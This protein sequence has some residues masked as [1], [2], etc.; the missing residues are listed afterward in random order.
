ME[1]KQAE[2]GGGTTEPE[3][4]TVVARR[5]GLRRVSFAAD[6]TSIHVF[7]RDED[8]ETPPDDKPSSE[9]NNAESA[10][11]N[12]SRGDSSAES[13]GFKESPRRR[14]D[15]DGG[16]DADDDEEERMLFVRNMDYSSPGSAA[17]SMTSND[18]DNFFGPVSTSFIRTG[19]LSMDSATSDDNHDITMDSTAFSLHFRNLV[20]SNER[21]SSSEGNFKTPTGVHLGFVEKSPSGDSMVT[22]GGNSM[23]LTGF[24]KSIHQNV[25]GGSSN[26]GGNSSDM[27]LIVENPNKYDYGKLSPTLDALLAEDQKKYQHASVS[28]QL[29]ISKSFKS[30]SSENK[31][32]PFY[33]HKSD[34]M[35]SQSSGKGKAQI[36]A[37]EPMSSVA[38]SDSIIK[39]SDQD[40]VGTGKISSHHFPTSADETLVADTTERVQIERQS[41]LIQLAH[42]DK[43]SLKD[44]LELSQPQKELNY[45]INGHSISPESKTSPM[46]LMIQQGN[47]AIVHFGDRAGEDHRFS[48][49][50]PIPISKSPLRALPDSQQRLT[51]SP[52]GRAISPLGKTTPMNMITQQDDGTILHV[53]DRGGDHHFSNS[54]TITVA[55][56]LLLALSNSQQTLT[57]SPK[58]CAISPQ[59]KSSPMNLILQQDDG[60]I[61]HVVDKTGGDHQFLHSSPI[62]IAK[63]P[64]L[65]LSD[66]QQRLTASLKDGQY[67]SHPVQSDG[68]NFEPSSPG[69]ISS[70]RTKRRRIFF[71]NSISA[72]TERIPIPLA[73]EQPCSP[74]NKAGTEDGGSISSIE[75]SVSN[76]KIHE[77]NQVPSLSVLA[78]KSSLFKD[79]CIE[80][81]RDPISVS[82]DPFVSS[83][84]ARLMDTAEHSLAPEIAVDMLDSQVETPQNF[85][86]F[87]LSG[88]SPAI[89]HDRGHGLGKHNNEYSG[90]YHNPVEGALSTALPYSSET[91]KTAE[92][93]NIKQVTGTPIRFISSP[94][95]REEKFCLSGG[96]EEELSRIPSQQD[97]SGTLVG[98]SRRQ[99]IE[100][101]LRTSETISL[102]LTPRNEGT[103]MSSSFLKENREHSKWK[104]TSSEEPSL[105]DLQKEMSSTMSYQTPT[106][107]RVALKFHSKSQEKN[108]QNRM[109]QSTFDEKFF[110]HSDLTA[111]SCESAPP[112]ICKS[113]GL[114]SFSEKKLGAQFIQSAS[115]NEV[116]NL[117]E[118]D[119][120]LSPPRKVQVSSMPLQDMREFNDSDREMSLNS[121]KRSSFVVNVDGSRRKISD[122]ISAMEKNCGDK[123]GRNN[124]SKVVPGVEGTVSGFL[125]RN[126]VVGSSEEAMI[127]GESSLKH[128][129]DLSSKFSAAADQLL[130]TSSNKLNSREL[131]ILD[132]MLGQMQKVR[133]Y[134]RICTEVQS[135][136]MHQHQGNMKQQRVVEA[137]WVQH[138]L[139]FEHAKLQLLHLKRDK[140]LEKAQ[141]LQSGIQDCRSL[142]FNKFQHLPL[143][144]RGTK[145]E[146]TNV[147]SL[148][149]ECNAENQ[150]SHH[151][152]VAMRKELGVLGQKLKKLITFFQA[153]CKIKG[154]RS[155][156]E[157]VAF[158]KDHLQKQKHRR[159]I[160]Q[161]LLL[162][163]LAGV[164]RTD[165]HRNI[166]LNYCGF[167]CQRLT[168][169]NALSSFSSSNL[170]NNA[171]I[172]MNFPNMN[173][174]KAFE[175]VFSVINNCKLRSQKGFQQLTQA[176][177]LLL[178]NLLDV[179][180][181][182][183]AAQM[184]LSNLINTHFNCPYVGHLD[185]QLDFIDF[186]TGRKVTLILDV[187]ELNRGIYPTE[188]VPSK[189]KIQIWGM[190]SVATL[191]ST[192]IL[193][194]VRSL[195]S[196]HHSVLTRLCQCVSQVV[197]SSSR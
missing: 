122:E 29:V 67:V 48:H 191:I 81:N 148:S 153:S 53:G 91:H 127:R 38:L 124:K 33:K 125:T 134:E 179:L 9:N 171:N 85:N 159:V 181:E 150:N 146:G 170:L 6:I 41:D 108:V 40:T 103:I 196:G 162:W 73:A 178:G 141:Q 131:D 62:P 52:K 117:M 47:G 32:S 155:T 16:D 43:K 30:P 188:I 165:D 133:K 74:S 114:R 20:Q 15:H 22:N 36:I 139:L 82:V 189:L 58:S 3:D 158:V 7:D 143:D 87:R 183:H 147:E 5:K 21:L 31:F 126:H 94:V 109:N 119:S 1:S 46:N 175:F 104:E 106:S 66:C 132:D 160:C 112:G 197:Q 71:G 68:N 164:E 61:V 59:T 145:S 70:L 172:K 93:M 182:V 78:R 77:T 26:R 69:S 120:L 101:S 12:E 169:N 176:A 137:R 84:E 129:G 98:S 39:S 28:N 89:F 11:R 72:S 118:N 140:L 142:K 2:D 88:K 193:D 90:A 136:K 154:E 50:S 64:L 14:G 105:L 57:A 152:V 37:G 35:D 195:K 86:V 99:Q 13:D 92:V 27:S 42:M 151:K 163:E 177:R 111:S 144:R 79:V 45:A 128:W 8:F 138:M 102:L 115:R 156:D 123:I 23:M 121:L 113:T 190:Q 56:S 54:S 130:P 107:Y 76:T 110:P 95:K 187:T 44:A 25:S 83:V 149:V 80:N 65:S 60:A 24:K 135:Q 49:S 161:Y 168:T 75:N 51:A 19:R 173:A 18:D 167:L 17:G 100:D 34:L 63:S 180:E 186:K 116:F 55:K 157:I 166:L 10:Q 185:L 96:L 192:E 184:E 97:Q 194:A 174:N 4:E